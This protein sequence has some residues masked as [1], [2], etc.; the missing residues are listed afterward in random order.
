MVSVCVTALLELKLL[1]PKNENALPMTKHSF[2]RLYL[3]VKLE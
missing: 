1:V 3:T 2:Q